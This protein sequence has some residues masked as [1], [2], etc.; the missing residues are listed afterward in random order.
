MKR[1]KKSDKAAAINFVTKTIL[2]ITAILKL[3]KAVIEIGE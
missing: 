1:K 3:I 2:L